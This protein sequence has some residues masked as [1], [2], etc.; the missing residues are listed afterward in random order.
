MAHGLNVQNMQRIASYALQYE[1]DKSS[2]IYSLTIDLEKI[3][4]DENFGA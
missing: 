4:K 2:K 3:G 1:Y